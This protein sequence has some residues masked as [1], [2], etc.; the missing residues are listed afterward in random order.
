[1]L[2]GVAGEWLH[3]GLRWLHVVAGAAW[4]GTSFYFNFLTHSLRPPPG[5]S[6]RVS[7]E[8]WAV[9]GGGFYHVEKFAVAPEALPETLH[10]FK[11][12]AYTTWLSGFSLL[13]VVYYLGPG[14]LMVDPGVADI[15]RATATVV[16]L[17]VLAVGW[18]VYDGLCR[19]PLV[20][21]TGAFTVVGFVLS[22]VVAY[23][24]TQVLAGR[25]AYIHVGAMLGTIMAANVF[26]VIIPSQRE[27]V[28]AMEQQREPDGELGRQAGLRSL[29][30]NYLTLPVLF[31]MVSNHFPTTYGHAWNWAILAGVSLGGAAIRHWFNLRGQGRRN[32]YILPVAAALLLATAF[33]TVPRDAATGADGAAGGARVSDDQAFA[34]MGRRCAAC[35]SAD[36]T[37]DGF[38]A[39]PAGIAFDE[40]EQVV[41]E[42]AR[43][44]RVAVD[45]TFMPLGN[46]TGMTDEER[47]TLGRWIDQR[48]Q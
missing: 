16:G 30:N 35:H 12:E 23:G 38:D 29:H 28:A 46:Q 33:V 48:Q 15:S 9:H 14:G 25:A 5:G 37:M 26:R 36:P 19:T 4:I 43:I 27:M 1:M 47:A 13:A 21:R 10:W 41:A 7:G 40:L 6:A 20:D 18:V 3:L 44:R 45:T 34:I 32:V 42:L 24:L 11:W 22:V 17:A 31:V 39:P 8:L 2:D